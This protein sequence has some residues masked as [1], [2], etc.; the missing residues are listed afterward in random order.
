[1]LY[2]RTGL[3]ILLEKPSE[4]LN[5]KRVGFVT[6]HTGVTK[7]LK[8]I[9]DV[10]YQHPDTNLA[11][12]FAPEHG[13]RGDAT[14][15]IESYSD[16]NTG[17]PIFSLY[18][19]TY[20]PTME[21]LGNLD[22]LMFDIQDVG[23]RFY[24][25][26]WTMSYGMESAAEVGLPFVVL[27]RPNPIN[28]ISVEGNILDLKFKSFVGRYPIPLRHGMTVGELAML[29]NAEFSINADLTVVRMKNWSRDMWFDD[30]GLIWVQPSP[31]MSTLD[32]AIVYPGTCLF[33]GTNVSEGRGTTKPYEWIGAPW[34]NS[35]KI[36][37]DL[38]S[39]KLP[40]VIFRAVYFT[41]TS[42]RY[43]YPGEM[44][45]GVQVHVVD[46]KI[47]KPIETGLHMIAA[48]RR[49]YP[50][51]FQWREPRPGETQ[52]PFDKLAG[53][54]KIRLQLEKDLPVSE[55]V[56][57]WQKELAVFMEKRKTYLLY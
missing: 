38:N 46:R 44:C 21:M 33:E 13:I 10:L 19:K 23:V 28:G 52:L 48:I 43:K 4:L 40:G 9:V 12:L 32:T 47:F 3:D 57:D 29:L 56:E 25:Y 35:M 54:D 22:V 34:I 6:N 18:G 1:M 26:I 20:K 37:A 50:D 41:S 17:L 36:A 49:L 11:A 7:D 16:E 5:N 31:N 51:R 30:T 42:S 15:A 24:T 14:S 8:H 39:R 27:D 45:G 53:T 55:I 2:V